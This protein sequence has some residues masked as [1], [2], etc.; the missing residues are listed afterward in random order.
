M[1][2]WKQIL[3]PVRMEIIQILAGGKKYTPA[4]IATYIP[5][6]PKATLYRHIKF[7]HDNGIIVVDEEI[8]KRGT[9]EKVYK[10]EMDAS[11]LSQKEI[12]N[13]TK[14]E[15]LDLFTHFI[16][17][18]VNDYGNYLNKDNIDLYRDGVGYS[19][20]ILYLSDEEFL[21]MSTQLRDLFMKYQ[22]NEPTSERKKR[23]FTTIIMPDEQKE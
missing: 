8:Q 3:H 12:E 17:G 16:S 9:V 2:K 18:V 23:K 4:Q 19:Q 5:T 13:F 22:I 11:R 1:K 7:L 20:A 14:E 15:H 21:E 10:L 6:I